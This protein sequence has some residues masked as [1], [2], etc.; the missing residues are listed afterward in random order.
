MSKL[1]ILSNTDCRSCIDTKREGSYLLESRPYLGNFNRIPDSID[2]NA[3]SLNAKNFFA[4]SF[5]NRG[6]FV[7]KKD[8]RKVELQPI[9]FRD[10][11][12]TYVSNKG[13]QWFIG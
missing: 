3:E 7:H 12:S 2:A 8:G 6:Y 5:N 11:D 13:N 4:F 1:Y 10:T 9:N